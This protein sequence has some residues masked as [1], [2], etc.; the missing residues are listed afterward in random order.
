[1]SLIV[2]YDLTFLEVMY[3]SEGITT[4][5]TIVSKDTPS[6]EI[7]CDRYKLLWVNPKIDSTIVPV[8]GERYAPMLR[9]RV[10][11]EYYTAHE[12]IRDHF[13]EFI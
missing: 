12:F 5:G 8:V 7:E 9:Y 1:M 3:I 10:F 13:S 4:L 2:E 6:R 11:P